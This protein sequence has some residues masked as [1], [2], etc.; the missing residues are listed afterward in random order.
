MKVFQLARSLREA[1]ASRWPHFLPH[2]FPSA[3]TWAKKLYYAAPIYAYPDAWHYWIPNELEEIAPYQECLFHRSKFFA[4]LIFFGLRL[5]LIWFFF[6]KPSPFNSSAAWACERHPFFFFFFFFFGKKITNS[7]VQGLWFCQ[8]IRQVP[9]E[10]NLNSSARTELSGSS[11]RPYV[12]RGLAWE[13]V[14]GFGR[15]ERSKRGLNW[16]SLWRI[17]LALTSSK[18]SWLVSKEVNKISNFPDRDGPQ[19]PAIFFSAS[20]A[21]AFLSNQLRTVPRLLQCREANGR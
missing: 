13:L 19:I 12:Q 15:I 9:S 21:W 14:K 3:R 10:W 20:L 5:W 8:P 7:P 17:W 2:Q 18:I 16:C 11:H 6:E 4:V 1:D